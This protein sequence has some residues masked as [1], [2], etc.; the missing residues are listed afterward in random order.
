MDYLWLPCNKSL[1]SLRPGEIIGVFNRRVAGWDGSFDRPVIELLG[2]G[3]HLPTVWDEKIRSFRE[4]TII[5][6]MRKETYE[7]LGTL[8]TDDDITI[9]GGYTNSVTHELV[10]LVGVEIADT[11]LPQILEYALQ[12]KDEDTCG[13]Y[14]GRISDVM[15]DYRNNPDPYAGGRT[16]APT[17]FPN[18][19]ELMEKLDAFILDKMLSQP[20]A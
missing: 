7:E 15:K 9:I 12:N 8:I 17:N 1:T 2:A 3:G 14:L 18:Q 10:I 6:N 16:S 11:V 4:L 20:L 5:E 13:I 19:P